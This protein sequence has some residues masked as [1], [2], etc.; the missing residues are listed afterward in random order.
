MALMIELLVM[1]AMGAL[2]WLGGQSGVAHALAKASAISAT[3][4]RTVEEIHAQAQRSCLF[5]AAGIAALMLGRLVSAR[6]GVV[7]IPSNLIM[8]ATCAALAIGFA[9]QMGYGDPLQ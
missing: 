8:P 1:A 7:N 3:E 5:F 2:G 9:L 4:V 6:R